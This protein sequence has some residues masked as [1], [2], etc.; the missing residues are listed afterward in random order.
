MMT[1]AMT[2]EHEEPAIKANELGTCTS[3]PND[4]PTQCQRPIDYS[5]VRAAVRTLREAQEQVFNRISE[6]ERFYLGAAAAS[7]AFGIT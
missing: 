6:T 4:V 3:G 1:T 2:N 5:A 7:A